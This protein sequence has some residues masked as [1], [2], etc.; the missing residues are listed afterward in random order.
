MW[1]AQT[2]DKNIH[3]DPHC[4]EVPYMRMVGAGVGASHCLQ[5]AGKWWVEGV[6]MWLEHLQLQQGAGPPCS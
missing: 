1:G 6:R 2:G 4:L 3:L 5:R